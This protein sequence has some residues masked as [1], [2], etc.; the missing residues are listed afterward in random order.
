M[1]ELRKDPIL[2]CWVII[3]ENRAARPNEFERLPPRRPTV[4]CPFCEGHEAETPTEISSRPQPGG[5]A[6][7]HRWSV[8][9]V[10]NKYPALQAPGEPGNL[11]GMSTASDTDVARSDLFRAT[12]GAGAH[13]VIIETPRH[14]TRTSDLTEDELRVVLDVY[15]ER[16]AHW[17][18]D[19][20]FAYGA[21]FK[22][23]G[24]PAGASLEH[25]HSQLMV[26]AEVPVAVRAELDAARAS[27]AE[28]GRCV[29]CAIADEEM[30]LSSR[31]VYTSADFVAF[32]PFA[33]RFPFETWILP[34]RHASHFENIDDA[35]L[36]SLA[37]A[38][39]QVLGRIELVGEHPAYN[40]VLRTAP[41]DK[42]PLDHYH[43]RIE[44]LPRMTQIAG[45]EWGSG[46][47]INP[48]APER[49]ARVLREIDF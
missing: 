34:R 36:K 23:L 14:A 5:T 21:L 24:Q 20:R 6:D 19:G 29:Y 7:D 33:S 27:F 38:A 12:P 11:G 13:E 39:R 37:T 28:H 18:Q 17:K 2:N 9:V 26:L 10:P 43:W 35:S 8:R 16:L 1:S 47:F 4:T 48:V 45:F 22:N 41:F 30:A 3:A 46:C 40:V 32:C 15:R 42:S 31:V 25:L 49:A 44:I